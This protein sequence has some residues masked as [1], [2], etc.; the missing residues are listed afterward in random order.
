M[1]KRGMKWIGPA[2]AFTLVE[3][4]I[5][6]SILAL[7]LGLLLPALSSARGTARGA[8]C[9][10]GVR[11]LQVAND[12]YADDHNGSFVPGAAE[13]LA[14]RHRWHGARDGATGAFDPARG[15]LVDYL[16]GA[17]ASV[18]IRACPEFEPVLNALTDRGVGFEAG[19]GGYGYNN[20]FVGV[21]RELNSVGAWIIAHDGE[22]QARDHV[23]APRAKF[24][25]PA[26]T[27]AFADAAFA[28]DRAGGLIEY[29]FL[30]PRHWPE[31][32][33]A[34][35]D[36]SVH[37]RHK[38]RASIAWLDGHATIELRRFEV[39]QGYL[40]RDPGAHGLGWMGDHDDN[41]LYDYE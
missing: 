17:G 39:N 25:S 16:D 31:Y 15:P 28:D 18:R 11:Q 4:L 35:P 29:S 8:V 23:G 6:L 5:V 7:L 3:L 26:R 40:S 22:G 30:E 13:F 21:E 2:R 24:A 1:T 32:P 10:S 9:L 34:R 20:A 37:F 12:L 41:R 36:P 33:G 27:I 19:G 38:G 14:N